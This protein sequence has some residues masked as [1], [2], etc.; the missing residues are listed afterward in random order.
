MIRFL[1]RGTNRKNRWKPV[2]HGGAD[3]LPYFQQETS[4][5]TVKVE[6]EQVASGNSL[7]RS[8]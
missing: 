8:F 2:R 4:G 3:I 7:K 1:V 5:Q 6:A